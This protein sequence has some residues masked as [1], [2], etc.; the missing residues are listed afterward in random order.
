MTDRA[1]A[2]ET[3][4][5]RIARV[6]QGLV[7]HYHERVASFREENATLPEGET[8]VVFVGD[9]LTEGF[10]LERHFPD[11]PTLNRGIRAD[12][13][14]PTPNMPPGV[15]LLERLDESIFET[16]PRLFHFLLGANHV[17]DPDFDAE[18][19]VEIYS[20]VLRQTREAFPDAPI[21][22]TTATPFGR[23]RPDA[24]TANPRIVEYN[25]RLVEMAD[26]L[27]ADLFDLHGLLV[28]EDGYLPD[29]DTR[30]GV[31]LSEEAY[32]KWAGA[33]RPVL[34]RLLEEA[35]VP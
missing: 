26:D 33:M 2:T 24:G 3:E 32:G 25:A 16:Q 28:D 11:L 6:V 19:L 34:D 20:D 31:H 17:P 8:Y 23:V 22:V 35:K 5:E 10:S 30:D 7:R 15:G 21:V 4:E 1:D 12:G 27:G 29:D 13:F 9:S 14:T 18:A